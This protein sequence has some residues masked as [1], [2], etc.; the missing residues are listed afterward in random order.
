MGD[1][2]RERAV[3]LRKM[4]SLRHKFADWLRRLSW[5]IDVPLDE[6][7]DFEE[8]MG[9]DVPIDACCEEWE[10]VDVED[11]LK[12]HPFCMERILGESE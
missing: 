5:K 9:C 8:C 3:N 10:Y 11:G 1:D 7:H 12:A 4:T 2:G 6:Q